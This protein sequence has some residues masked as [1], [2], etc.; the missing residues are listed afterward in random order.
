MFSF[1]VICICFLGSF[2]EAKKGGGC[3]PLLDTQAIEEA[4]EQCR[5]RSL[6]GQGFARPNSFV[7]FI[8]PFA[9]DT[10]RRAGRHNA[11]FIRIKI[12]ERKKRALYLQFVPEILSN[13]DRINRARFLSRIFLSSLHVFGGSFVCGLER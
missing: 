9:R 3:P 11:D 4:K 2:A 5:L 1:I 12:S 6:S 8:R 7:D 13:A 10:L